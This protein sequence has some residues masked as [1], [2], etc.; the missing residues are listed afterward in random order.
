MMFPGHHT[1]S[2]LHSLEGVG[3]CDGLVDE[4]R[5]LHVLGETLQKTE[6]LIENHWHCNL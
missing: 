5:V 3:G 2:H 1:V 4:V 6:W